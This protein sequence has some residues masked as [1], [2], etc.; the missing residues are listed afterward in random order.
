VSVSRLVDDFHVMGKL[1]DVLTC[2]DQAIIKTE[3]INILTKKFD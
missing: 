3:R 1:L 2:S